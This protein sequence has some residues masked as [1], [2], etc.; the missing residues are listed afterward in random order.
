MKTA[1]LSRLL[2]PLSLLV[3]VVFVGIFP[4]GI[5]PNDTFNS[6]A[7]FTLIGAI[8]VVG[9]NIFSGSEPIPLV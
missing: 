5:A 4:V 3:L 9:W 1:H 7:V 2:G 8:A 6:I